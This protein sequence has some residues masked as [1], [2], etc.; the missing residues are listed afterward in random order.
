MHKKKGKIQNQDI[1]KSGRKNNKQSEQQ[2]I[3][4]SLKYENT[5]QK[6]TGWEVDLVREDM[7]KCMGNQ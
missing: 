5:E 2:Q 4:Y 1:G 6:I 7:Q 3:L